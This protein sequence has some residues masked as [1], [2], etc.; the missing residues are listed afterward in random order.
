MK[1][2]IRKAAF[3][4]FVMYCFLNSA[5]ANQD[6]LI[7]I[8]I[9]KTKQ[10]SASSV[11]K[12]F[13]KDLKRMSDLYYTKNFADS[14]TT[15]KKFESLKS[16][17][18][19]KLKREGDF[20]YVGLSMIRYENENVP[21]V[22][23]DVVDKNDKNRMVKFLP[24][25]ANEEPDPDKLIENWQSYQKTGIRIFLNENKFPTYKIC[26]AHHCIFGFEDKRLKKYGDIFNSKVPENKNKLIL[27]LRGDKDPEKRSSA[28]Y[29]LAHIKDG[30]ELVDILTPS[31]YDSSPGVRN[32][33]M[34]VLGETVAKDKITNFPVAPLLKALDFPDTS[35]RNKALYILFSLASQP[36][37]AA[38]VK[39]HALDLLLSEL[40]LLQPNV[41]V[42]AYE[43]L[44]KIS[45]KKYTDV[46]YVSWQ[47]WAN[48]Q[49]KN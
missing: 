15:G 33:V 2:E 27:V 34:R 16:K 47:N 42:L 43:T 18:I 32:A 23:I 37:Y 39:K 13:G 38:F 24:A 30:R 6:G 48:S 29:L 22:T 44:K 36:K 12:E 31:I 9:Y 41:H 3:D 20:D 25:P 17:I 26:P 35:D 45:G 7:T 10:L 8:D 11:G 21:H 1:S 49:N 40:R 5:F 19:S 46:D 28:A 4:A 14:T